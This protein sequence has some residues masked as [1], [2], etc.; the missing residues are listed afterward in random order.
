M[1][2]YAV[3]G[4][5][6]K[7]V[8]KA[9]AERTFDLPNTRFQEI[10]TKATEGKGTISL[11]IGE[12]DF[13]TPKHIVQATKKALDNG[14]THYSAPQ[15]F[16]ELRKAIAEK[17]KKENKIDCDEKNVIVT[18][19]SNEAILLSIINLI[20]PG[21]EILCP[22][23]GFLS[24]IPTIELMNGN[25]K[26]YSLKEENDFQIDIEELKELVSNKTRAILINTPSNP[27]GSVL[28]KKCLE[29][30]RDFA[31]EN[32]LMIISDE[33]YEKL[34]FGEEKHI[35]I[36]SLNGMKER[37]ITIQSFSKSYAMPGFRVGYAIAPEWFIKTLIRI[38]M[39]SSLCTPTMNQIA[40][41][42]ALNGNQK[43]VETMRKE[44]DK[45]RKIVLERIA[46]LDELNISSKPS[47]AFYAFPR[48]ENKM[49]SQQMA[50]FLLKKARVLTV[51]GTEFGSHGENHIRISYSAHR[52]LIQKAFDR[53][54]KAFKK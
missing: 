41:E 10:M 50:N 36:A 46:E 40:A 53:I 30:I 24:Y 52:E 39:Y 23:P 35:S 27:T 6:K 38:K 28:K 16:L 4:W 13:P 33:A 29:K 12:P 7:I 47:G 1:H 11:S 18:T 5:K 43:C 19:G 9:W 45:R 49:N 51:P 2:K 3:E 25:P 31:I 17:A 22:N 20:D 54:E 37:A 8:D 26:T 34:V 14:Y 44:Y 21:E 15:G 42:T 32:N 48:I